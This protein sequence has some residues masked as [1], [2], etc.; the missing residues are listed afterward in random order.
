MQ[1][2]KCS[3]N[4][5]ITSEDE[6]FYAKLS[7]PSPVLCLDCRRQRRFAFRNERA[8]YSRACDLCKK[9]TVS[10]YSPS[11]SGPVY[12]QPCWWSDNW[13]PFTYG[14]TYDPSRPF[15][16]QLKELFRAVPLPSLISVSSENSEFTVHSFNNKNCYLLISCGLN[17]DCFYGIQIV[18]SRN[19]MDAAFARGSE[20]G[21]ELVDC[22][23]MYHSR[24]CQKSSNCLDS[25]F[26][27]DCHGCSDCF[28]SVNLRNKQYVF[29]NEQL[30]KDTYERAIAEVRFGRFDEVE[31]LKKEFTSYVQQSAIHKY[32]TLTHCEDVTGNYLLNCT[33]A[34][35][36]FDARNLENCKYIVVSPGPT[37][38][39]YDMNYCALGSE[40][41]CDVLS[42]V[43]SATNQQYCQ[44]SWASSNLQYCSYVMNSNDCFGSQGLR[45]VK[46]CILNRQYSEDEYAALRAQIIKDMRQ[47]GEYGQFFPSSLS[48]LGYNETSSY[49]EWALSKEDAL[50]QGFN[51]CDETAGKFEKPTKE[52]GA[53]PDDIAHVDESIMREVL[54][55]SD[56]GKNFKIIK[57][58]LAFYK[59]MNVPL[60]RRC[61]DCRHIARMHMRNPRTLW[62]RQCMCDLAQRRVGS[63]GH[64]HGGRC[65][66]EFETTYS[67]DRPEKV[68]C[69]GCYQEEVV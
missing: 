21:Y 28:F 63:P 67:P 10:F 40:L 12:C 49:D 65:P 38:D 33:N 46:F 35:E 27:Y 31:M 47:R 50:A 25:S 11:Y 62:P 29:R 7:V 1:Y 30:S 54:A 48:P 8:L 42:N 20:R 26:L 69:E 59:K 17:E 57:A 19:V 41:F 53:T 51:W 44:Y 68:F 36:C 55:C 5:V 23:K 56:C 2:K 37:K 34:R 6:S 16:D 60:P 52:W 39:C 18:E 45:K 4:F 64:D 14:R 61:F 13:D 58:E 3:D 22:E 43:E 66:L 9:I 24:W 32:A 15:F